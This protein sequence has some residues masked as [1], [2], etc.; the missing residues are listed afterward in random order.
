[1]PGLVFISHSSDDHA[2]VDALSSALREVFQDRLRVFNAAS[3]DAVDPGGD[4]REQLL[5]SMSAAAVVVL[6]ATSSALRSKE[7]AFEIG[8]AY[9]SKNQI[10]PCCVHIPPEELPWGLSRRQALKLDSEAGW[11]QLADQIATII[12]FQGNLDLEPL[13]GLARRFEAPDDALSV[14][15]LGYT[16][17]LENRSKSHISNIQVSAA[18]GSPPPAWAGGFDVQALAPGKS[19]VMFREH[20]AS[21]VDLDLSWIDVTGALRKRRI[22]VPAIEGID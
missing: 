9:A 2:D 1:M 15:A 8:A 3:V 5:D 19:V 17:E 21:A 10:I 4:W 12:N 7:V 22:T 11:V 20:G 16:V 18:D 6:W 14:D 13:K